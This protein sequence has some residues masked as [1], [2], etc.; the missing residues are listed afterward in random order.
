MNLAKD[1]ETDDSETAML[2]DIQDQQ[3][4]AHGKKF[5]DVMF[6]GQTN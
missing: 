5:V 6:H 1:N 2:W 3:I 4:E